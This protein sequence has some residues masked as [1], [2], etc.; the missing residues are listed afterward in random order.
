MLQSTTRLFERYLRV[1]VNVVLTLDTRLFPTSTLR[2]SRY[3]YDTISCYNVRNADRYFDRNQSAQNW[4]NGP[5]WNSRS[6]QSFV[7]RLDHAW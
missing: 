7:L 1:N 2:Q 5:G 3:I 4:K 6:H